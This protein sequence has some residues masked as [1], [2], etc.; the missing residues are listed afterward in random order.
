[1]IAAYNLMYQSEQQYLDNIAKVPPNLR[2]Y[3]SRQHESIPEA[4]NKLSY[5]EGKHYQ[6]ADST[7]SNL[8]NFPNDFQILLTLEADFSKKR[9]VLKT[10][11]D[12]VRKSNN[13]V[14]SAKVALIKAQ[15]SGKQTNINQAK[16]NLS[17]A[18]RKLEDD[19]KSKEKF[20]QQLKEDEIPYK[21]RFLD[22]YVT[23]VSALLDLRSKEADE[24]ANLVD[25]YLSA[26]EKFTDLQEN[27]STQEKWNK[28]KDEYD[29]LWE[30][31]NEKSAGKDNE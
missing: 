10:Y 2:E 12:S 1:M 19:T 27:S 5:L 17:A 15:S 30:E 7:H 28:E 31:L 23:Q 8:R 20:E 6:I 18:E 21:S 26:I 22:S 14:E 24:Y 3:A 25:D 9:D 16:Q 11:E 13:A 4:L 29:Q